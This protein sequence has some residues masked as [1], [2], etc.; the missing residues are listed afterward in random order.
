MDETISAIDTV[1]LRIPLDIW[2][3]A[4]HSDLR[5]LSNEP[6][7]ANHTIEDMQLDKTS[8]KKYLDS[9]GAAPLIKSVIEQAYK[10]E[11]GLE[12]D[13]QSCFNFLL[14]IHA[15]RRSKF[16]PF[17]IFSDERYHVVDGNDR[18]V[19]GLRDRVPGQVRLDMRLVRALKTATAKIELGFAQGASIK[20]ATFDAVVL[21]LPFKTLREVDLDASL[22]LLTWKKTRLKGWVTAQMPR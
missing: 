21:A 6:T 3:P 10:A 2:V 19:E 13:E 14:F 5:K 17:G 15:D 18:I 20:Q 11:Y 12:I 1:T 4:L 16:T 22:G 8:L 7:A 9:R